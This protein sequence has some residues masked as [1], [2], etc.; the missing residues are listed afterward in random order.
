[1]IVEEP[2][3]VAVQMKSQKI[4]RAAGGTRTSFIDPGMMGHCAFK[5]ASCSAAELAQSISVMSFDIL[6]QASGSHKSLVKRGLQVGRIVTKV[7]DTKAGEMVELELYV[8]TGN[9]MGANLVTKVMQ[10]VS[11]YV[12]ERLNCQRVISILSNYSEQIGSAEISLPFSLLGIVAAGKDMKWEG[13]I[14]PDSI[15]KTVSEGIFDAWAFADV[16]VARATTHNKG[17]MNG[18]DAILLATGNDFRAVEA[19]AYAHASRSGVI[20]LL[21]SW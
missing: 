14:T 11:E 15:G 3:V 19:A 2:S 18:V 20:K 21:T 7:L 16:D 5:P 9:S 6:S 17:I 8:P 1:M 13:K 12:I 10:K 4:F